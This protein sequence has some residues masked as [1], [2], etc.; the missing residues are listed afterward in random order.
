M[1]ISTKRCLVRRC[2]PTLGVIL[3]CVLKNPKMRHKLILLFEKL[4]K[5]KLVKEYFLRQNS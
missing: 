3:G 5:T 4:N 1:G 2:N